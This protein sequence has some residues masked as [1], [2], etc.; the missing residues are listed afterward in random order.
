MAWH[1]SIPAVLLL[2]LTVP[3][4]KGNA[5]RAPVAAPVVRRIRDDDSSQRKLQ[6]NQTRQKRR[7]DE[8]N[9]DALSPSDETITQAGEYLRLCAESR[10]PNETTRVEWERFYRHCDATIR[11]FAGTFRGRGVDVDDCTQEVWADLIRSLPHFKLD[12]PRGRFDSWLYTIVRSKATDILRRQDR[13]PTTDLSPAVMACVTT[14]EADP[15][16]ILAR[17][18][19][20]DLVQRAMKRLQETASESSYRVLHLRYFAGWNVQQV[21]ESLGF[22]REQ[23]WVREHRM[24]RKLRDL[25]ADQFEVPTALGD[26]CVSG[27][28]KI[29]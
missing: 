26:T 13:R 10:S 17:Q 12:S 15:S 6:A 16:E 23:V 3:A 29:A 19:D 22:S 2:T 5:G 25:L 1:R 9:Q 20:C 24:K 4:A 18:S 28:R 7:A 8:S 27:S 21:A 11:R 14:S